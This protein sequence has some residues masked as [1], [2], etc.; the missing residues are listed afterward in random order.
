MLATGDSQIS[1]IG[2]DGQRFTGNFLKNIREP[3]NM[4]CRAAS[5]FETVLEEQRT[6]YEI[7][8]GCV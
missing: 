1:V 5:G 4:Q 7:P 2:A 8:L 6:T 3:I